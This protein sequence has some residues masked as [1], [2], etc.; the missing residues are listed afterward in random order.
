MLVV[1]SCFIYHLYSIQEIVLDFVQ[2]NIWELYENQNIPHTPS[3][4]RPLRASLDAGHISATQ[5]VVS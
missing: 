5:A 1:I 2:H 3:P 4:P